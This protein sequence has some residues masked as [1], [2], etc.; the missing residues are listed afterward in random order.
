M[1]IHILGI[2]GTFM[3]GIA[4]LAKELGF[5]VTGSDK[6]S[7]PPISTQLKEQGIDIQL[8]YQTAH[9]LPAPDEIIVGNVITRGMESI[10]YVLNHQLNYI[11]GPE[12]LRKN[13]VSN[14]TVIAISGTHGK[15]T[16]AS[17]VA[18]ILEYA[19]LNPGFLIGGVAENLKLSAR[20]GQ[21]EYFI[22]E[23]DEYDSAFFD[24]R[25]KFIHYHPKILVINNLEFDHAD[26]F[27]SVKDIQ[28]QF[29][30]LIK[31]VPS[32]GHIIYHQ[33]SPL[34]EETL[35]KGLW[36]KTQ[37]FAQQG[38]NWT[39]GSLK[40]ENQFTVDFDGETVGEINWS[41][42]GEHNRLNAL[43][44]LS[45]VQTIGIEPKLAIAAL[46]QFK[47]VKRRL[48]SK[49]FIQEVEI[50]DDFA[51]HPTAIQLTLQAM[52]KQFTDKKTRIIAVIDI[53]SNTMRGG[54]HKE[55]LP[56][57]V[58]AADIVYFFYDVDMLWSVDELW[59]TVNKSG[60]IYSNLEDLLSHLKQVIQQQDKVV[61]MS[62]GA[63]SGQ[64]LL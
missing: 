9:L 16:T 37:T 4:L 10:E 5:K 23:A 52:K 40:K 28:K 34:I 22:I 51:H 8:G 33:G 57:S 45:A 2:C 21:G 14:R 54:Y 3:G 44:A 26:I 24:K 53:R 62:N 30:H 46:N 58:Q 63:L 27:D 20:L 7:Y 12:W 36:T 11:S 13:V 48:E 43:A 55:S 6:N 41:L 61:F 17:M 15:T 18:W 56:R 29:H 32:E 60:G 50:F 49:G 64:I 19:G 42:I 47:G 38:A 25:S 35:Q 31:T 1:H 39:I 59:Q